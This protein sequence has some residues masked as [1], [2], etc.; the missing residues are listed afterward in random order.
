MKK[1]FNMSYKERISDI[2]KI[3]DEL[4]NGEIS[5]SQAQEI[6]EAIY[7]D[8]VHKMLHKISNDIDTVVKD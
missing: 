8:E 5:K 7:I 6:I 3:L 2:N 4:L 1:D